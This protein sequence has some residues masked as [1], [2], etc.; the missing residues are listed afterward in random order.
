LGRPVRVK[1]L[2]IRIGADD[3]LVKTQRPEQISAGNVVAGVVRKIDLLDGQAMLTLS[4]GGEFYV[5]LT[6][7][8]VSR[9]RLVE[10]TSVF[11][12]MKTRSFR[13]L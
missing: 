9:L 3:I 10:E 2:Q 4:A 7:S 13:L 1:Q 6:A 5:R 12:I 8:A 11:L